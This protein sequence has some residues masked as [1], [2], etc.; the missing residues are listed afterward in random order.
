MI[1]AKNMKNVLTIPRKMRKT[2]T[3][4][5]SDMENELW[6]DPFKIGGFCDAERA[7]HREVTALLD[8][9]VDRLTRE[10]NAREKQRAAKAKRRK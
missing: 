10:L 4:R 3:A 6:S 1:S 7:L 9:Y 2:I 5:I 8:Y